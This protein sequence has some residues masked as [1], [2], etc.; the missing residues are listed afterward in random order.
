MNYIK[1]IKQLLSV[2]IIANNNID[3]ANFY[4]QLNL[5]INM[6]NKYGEI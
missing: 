4:T 6:Y 1:C 3:Q 2:F 5:F